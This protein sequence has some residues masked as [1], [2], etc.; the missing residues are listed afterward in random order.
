MV[1]GEQSAW[2]AFFTRCV[3]L[4]RNFEQIDNIKQVFV[5]K[6]VI[7]RPMEL[8]SV[9]GELWHGLLSCQGLI[10]GDATSLQIVVLVGG[11]HFTDDW[12]EQACLNFRL[13]VLVD[14][15]VD[16]DYLCSLFRGDLPN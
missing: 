11:L 15:S 6:E 10:G 5:V 2:K 9:I 8:L 12:V 1:A 13:K 14:L 3:V 4:V 16:L 7:E